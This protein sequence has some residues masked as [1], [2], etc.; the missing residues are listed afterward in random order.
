MVV[1]LLLTMI[2]ARFSASAERASEF[3]DLNYKLKF[4]H[5]VVTY[6]AAIYSERLAPQPFSLPRAL[7][8][9]AY[10]VFGR[11]AGVT[12][13]NAHGAAPR[14][15]TRSR[16]TAEGVAHRPVATWSSPPSTKTRESEFARQ[17]SRKPGSE[18][19]G[20][21]RAPTGWIS[22]VELQHMVG[23]ELDMA[24]VGPL[25][26]AEEVT[27]FMGRAL[28]D[29]QLFPEFVVEH[30][31]G[32]EHN[33]N[34]DSERNKWQLLME[35]I[36]TLV[37]KQDLAIAEVREKHTTL[38]GQVERLSSALHEQRELLA[39]AP[40]DATAR[41]RRSLAHAKTMS[42]GMARQSMVRPPATPE[43]P[44]PQPTQ[45]EGST[46]TS[47]RGSRQLRIAPLLSAVR[48]SAAMAGATQISSSRQIRSYST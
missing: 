11:I 17:R 45:Q 40:T 24:K 18:K 9:H 37:H 6:R 47:L 3:V 48:A 39:V 15:P 20:T 7:V 22:E 33:I 44:C 34:A 32:L 21:R 19:L 23:T 10:H 12:R 26:V 36:S 42:A 28:S 16:P 4:A 29:R 38:Q 46:S 1:L 13:K 43:G 31:M 14:S 5:M 41:H 25:Q 2:I 30:C 27:K 8:L 35:R